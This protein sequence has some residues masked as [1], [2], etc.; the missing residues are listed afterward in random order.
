MMIHNFGKSEF[1]TYLLQGKLLNVYYEGN[2]EGLNEGVS[3]DTAYISVLS[4]S[5]S[6]CSVEILRNSTE[7][8]HFGV[9]VF[10]LLANSVYYCSAIS[11]D[12][13]RTV[14]CW[15]FALC[16]IRPLTCTF[17]HRHRHTHTHTHTDCPYMPCTQLWWLLVWVF[18]R[19]SLNLFL[20]DCWCLSGYLSVCLL[21]ELRFICQQIRD[22]RTNNQSLILF[23]LFFN[24]M[25][26][27]KYLF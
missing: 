1:N 14:A 2:N 27:S 9:C 10:F 4:N 21:F 3:S 17:K 16:C 15:S 7:P 11:P 20:I 6:S 25:Q 5:R 12:Q 18:Y 26:F 13:L 22:T 19:F 8:H 24:T 23:E